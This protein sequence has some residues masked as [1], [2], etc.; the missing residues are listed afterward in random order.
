MIFRLIN[1]LLLVVCRITMWGLR[2]TGIFF[3][4]AVTVWVL[5]LISVFC[6]PVCEVCCKSVGVVFDQCVLSSSKWTVL[7]QC[8]CCVWSSACS[9]HQP[10]KCAVTVCVLC[11]IISVFCPSACEVCCNSVFC[12]SAYE[13]CCKQYGCCVWK[14][15]CRPACQLPDCRK[16]RSMRSANSCVMSPSPWRPTS[17]PT[18]P[19]HAAFWQMKVTTRGAPAFLLCCF[20]SI[21]FIFYICYCFIYREN[22]SVMDLCDS[23]L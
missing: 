23:W 15:C 20:S 21:L 17:C 2:V 19:S 11:L 5:Y 9:V 16:N 1:A 8:V 3:P 18:P 4:A 22:A 7:Q 12:P 10:V 6:L 13:E 14:V